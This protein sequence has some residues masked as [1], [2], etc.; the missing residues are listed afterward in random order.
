MRRAPSHAGSWYLA[1][2][3]RLGEQLDGW[4]AAASAADR[5]EAAEG[6]VGPPRILRALIAP[7]AG[8]SYS[9]PA[10]AYAYKHLAALGT[11]G[12]GN[13]PT[14]VFLLGPSHHFYTR[15][16]CLSGATHY[17]TPMG[18]IPVD[19]DGVV[20]ELRESGEF[21]PDMDP[22]QDED[23]HSLEMHLPYILRCLQG[24]GNFTLVPIL[25][26]NLDARAEERYGRLL[27]PYFADPANLFVASSD[28]CHWGT[29]FRFTPWD[30]SLGPIWKSVEAL[31]R[32]GMDAVASRDPARFRA[33]LEE[34]EN[35]VCGRHPIGVLM[36]ALKHAFAGEQGS[37]RPYGGDPYR[38]DWVRYEQSSRCET[39]ADSS[40]SYASAI[41]TVPART[42]AETPHEH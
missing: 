28:F 40:V 25:V 20:A 4:L 12:P 3:A 9:G 22:E 34:T 29:R 10:A 6:E 13:R 8:Y 18:D 35:T 32:R 33:Y 30:H 16:C 26:G 14:R 36:H 42:P 39:I 11:T 15:Q 27:A 41:V 7:H 17:G 24:P 38:V 19:V 31:D 1:D 5:V 37:Q 21:G 23:E 2:G